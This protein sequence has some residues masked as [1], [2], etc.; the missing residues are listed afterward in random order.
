MILVTN[1]QGLFTRVSPS[2]NAILGYQ[3]EE[4]VGHVAS[5]FIHP[6]DLEPTRNEMRLARRG[7]CLL[8]AG[9]CLAF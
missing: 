9:P 7:R 6:D 4:M 8:R 3:P 1:Q 5:E 2:S